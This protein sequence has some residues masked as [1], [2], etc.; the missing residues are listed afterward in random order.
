MLPF[1]VSI[2]AG[3]P[4]SE[5]VIYAVHKA[6]VGGQLEP[7]DPFPSVRIL[8]KELKINPNTAFKIVAHLKHEGLLEV[9]PG[10]GT[11]VSRNYRPLAT[12]KEELLERTIE[13]L[14]VEARKL[15]LKKQDVHKAI[16]SHWEKL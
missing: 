4:V 8:S 16:D 12:D 13:A 14:V 9:H 1:R 2:R 6:V 5:Q 15:G 11:F 10:R 3:E 7:G